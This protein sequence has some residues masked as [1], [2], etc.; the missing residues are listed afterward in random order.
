MSEYLGKSVDMK[1]ANLWWV[2][3]EHIRLF[4]YVYSYASGLLISKAMQKKYRRDKNFIEK[5]KLFLS[6]G[7]SKRPREIFKEL[8]IEISKDFFLEG[9]SEMERDFEEI[10]NLGKKLGKI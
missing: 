4:F 8:G 6:T 3:W 2:Y 5:I 9:L 7:T 1:N 10:K